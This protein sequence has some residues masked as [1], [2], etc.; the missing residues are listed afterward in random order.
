MLGE[1]QLNCDTFAIR[2]ALEG[3]KGRPE[4]SQTGE[5]FVDFGLEGVSHANETVCDSVNQV[6]V[7][8]LVFGLCPKQVNYLTRVG[9]FFV[10]FLPADVYIPLAS[11]LVVLTDLT[12][13]ADKLQEEEKFISPGLHILNEVDFQI[14]SC[15]KVSR[16]G[17]QPPNCPICHE[18]GL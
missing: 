8:D 9:R 3:L 1:E 11:G 5:W 17:Q 2:D 15:R 7:L 4:N 18:I 14:V 13:S 10:L 12:Q 16:L 6:D